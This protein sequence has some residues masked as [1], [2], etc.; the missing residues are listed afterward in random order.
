[1]A[2]VTSDARTSP[3]SPA[4]PSPPLPAISL[5]N[6][7]KEY[8]LDRGA[9]LRALDQF[10]LDVRDGE[11]VAVIGPSGCGKS[12]ALRLMASLEEPTT[13]TVLIEG[14]PPDEAISARRL[15][16]A[17]QDHA[18]LSWLTVW[19]NIALPFRIAKRKVVA[20]RIRSLIDLVGLSGFEQARPKHLSGGMKQR[21][22]IA[23]ALALEPE[24]LLLDEP[25]GSLDAVTRR[26]LNLELQAI[27]V[28]QSITTALVTHSVEEAVFM[29]DRVVVL[30][31][32]PGRIKLILDVP[33]ARPR[34]RELTLSPAFHGLTDELYL[35]LDEVSKAPGDQVAG[36]P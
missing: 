14:R 25:F 35:A 1:V 12:T 8:R 31:A 21:V 27:W 13:G 18:L 19:D 29:A 32:R 6:V 7:T 4:P 17:F 16:M 5:H 3:A 11:F 26:R 28:R 2:G 23:R 36:A 24:I 34:E 33:F 20:E 10:T 30:T 9:V 22:A 15:G